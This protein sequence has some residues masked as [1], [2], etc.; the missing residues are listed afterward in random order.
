MKSEV[1]KE[2]SSTFQ[3]LTTISF[4]N[5][6]TGL[7][8]VMREGLWNELCARDPYYWL[9]LHTKTFDEHWEKKGTQ[10]YNHFPDLPYLRNIFDLL[11]TESRLFLPK[12]REMM[13]TWAVIGY[14][15]WRCQFHPRTRVI[16]QTQ[17]LEKV[18]DLVS[19]RGNPGYA[20]TLWEQQNDFLKDMH[21]LVKPAKDMAAGLLAWVNG[22]TFQG[23]P[24]GADQVR[25]YHPTLVIFDE[26]AHLSEFREAYDAAHP[27]A[28]Q[29]IALSS[30]APSWFG[31]I[32][33]SAFAQR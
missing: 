5:L 12:S 7:R 21:P 19:G 8:K 25:Q 1:V 3:N 17:K 22:S 28:T 18:L 6:P 10:P 9:Q 33:E 23:V 15:V 20:R 4:Q 26:A 2:S 30:A 32:C 24:S 14:G 16:V 31:D 13:L 11:L 27:V 29:I